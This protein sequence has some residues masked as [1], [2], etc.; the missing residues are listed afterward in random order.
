MDTTT[1]VWRNIG[2]YEGKWTTTNQT[3]LNQVL[4]LKNEITRYPDKNIL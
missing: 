3:S 1:T 4:D 2:K